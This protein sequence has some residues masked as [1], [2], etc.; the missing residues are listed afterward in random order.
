MPQEISYLKGVAGKTVERI[1]VVNEAEFRCVT[2]DFTDRTSLQVDLHV[3]LNIDPE[4]QDWKTGNHRKLRKY[5]TVKESADSSHNVARH[6]KRRHRH[7]SALC[8]QLL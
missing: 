6:R 7:H 1:S 4:L 3:T 2:I 8:N 5:P